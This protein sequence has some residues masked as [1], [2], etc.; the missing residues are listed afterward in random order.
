MD[1]A[2]KRSLGAIEYLES[3]AVYK[4]KRNLIN[5]VAIIY[6]ERLLENVS[7]R[8]ERFIDYL[9]HPISFERNLIF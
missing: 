3:M 7:E 9:G 1:Y 6:G 2:V 4:I 5:S 8:F